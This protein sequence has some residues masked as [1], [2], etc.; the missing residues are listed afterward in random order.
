[1]DLSVYFSFVVVCIPRRV[2]RFPRFRD[3][4]MFSLN[5]FSG[6]KTVAAPPQAAHQPPAHNASHNPAV[7]SPSN[8]VSGYSG[9]PRDTT[10]SQTSGIDA[11]HVAS[12]PSV[13]HQPADKVRQS[14]VNQDILCS[15]LPPQNIPLNLP[16][17]PTTHAQI[18]S[19][20][21]ARFVDPS[22]SAVAKTEMPVLNRID[23]SRMSQ[24]SPPFS[25][26]DIGRRGPLQVR[27]IT[28]SPSDGFPNVPTDW[29]QQVNQERPEF[30]DGVWK[31]GQC[32]K[33][34]LQRVMLQVHVCSHMPNR[35]YQCG[36]CCK[37]FT[38][39]NELRTHAVVHSGKKPFKCGYCSRTFAGATTLNNH[40][41]THT[42]E[43][44]FTC[45]KCNKTFSQASQ[46]SR[47]KRCPYECVDK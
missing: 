45:D 26:P 39:P 31:C 47:H 5:Y 29:S 3:D 10:H 38:H 30:E 37:S 22:L 41:R 44:P 35:P 27:D 21:D 7:T 43:R 17:F 46:L 19:Q 33:S 9:M 24:K 4:I 12:R 32:D 36:H 1:M 42:G 25:A 18:S 6:N 14:S 2:N 23:C 40:V 13:P 11:H 34:F 15:D 8:S 16:H 28:S 20:H